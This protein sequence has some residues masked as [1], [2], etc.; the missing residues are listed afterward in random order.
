MATVA[1][2]V[3]SGARA[4]QRPGGFYRPGASQA[5]S[6]ERRANRNH[7]M[8]GKAVGDVQR[9]SGQWRMAERSRAC[10]RRP[11]VAGLGVAG[12]SRP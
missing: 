10:A 11:R 6:L 7:D 2:G 9:G 12:V 5:A 4:R 1:G 8:G 3:D